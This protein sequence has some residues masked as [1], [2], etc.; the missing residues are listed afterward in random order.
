[1]RIF[2]GFHRFILKLTIPNLFKAFFNCNLIFID[3]RT[4]SDSSINFQKVNLPGNYNQI[5]K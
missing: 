2:K 1:M 3:K 4:L 5:K